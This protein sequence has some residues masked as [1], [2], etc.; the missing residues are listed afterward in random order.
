MKG[1]TTYEEMTTY[2]RDDTRVYLGT[3]SVTGSWW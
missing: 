2:K 3:W 1:M